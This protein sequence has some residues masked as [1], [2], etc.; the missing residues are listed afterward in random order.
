[1]KKTI[2]I[3][4]IDAMSQFFNKNEMGSGI[5]YPNDYHKYLNECGEKMPVSFFFRLSK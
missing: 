5:W 4:V 2:S 1:M 3:A